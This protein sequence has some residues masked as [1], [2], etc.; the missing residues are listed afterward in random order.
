MDNIPESQPETEAPAPPTV[1][2]EAASA[3][4]PVPTAV[5]A[6]PPAPA[7][8]TSALSPAVETLTSLAEASRARR[9]APA[10]EDRAGALLKEL[11]SA[12]RTG[13]NSAFGPLITLPWIVGVN[14]VAAVWPG[15]TIP[16]RRHLLAILAKDESE[17]ARRLRLSLGRAIFKLEPAA[18]L[19]LAVAATADL[20]DPETGSLS[21]KHRQIFFNVFVGKGK[22]WLLQMPLGDLKGADADGFVHCAIETFP[23][24]PPLSQLS[25]LR[26]ANGAGRLKKL[27]PADLEIATKSI[28]RWNGK[29]Q[30]LLKAEISELPEAIVAVLKPETLQ[31]APME[32]EAGGQEQTAAEE[33]VAAGETKTPVKPREPVNLALQQQRRRTA[34]ID[35]APARPGS[36]K[37]APTQSVSDQPAP[38]TPAPPEE[39]N[40]PSRAARLGKI[41]PKPEREDRDRP[42]A[43]AEKPEQR[44]RE[45]RRDERP[46][47][48]VREDK[49][50]K[51]F[52]FKES[53][54]GLE[55][56]V[57][58]IR[59]ELE[60][61]K[62]QLRRREEDSKRGGRTIRGAEE[63]PSVDTEALIRHNAQLESAVQQLRQQLEDLA[64]HHEAVAESR[65]LHTDSPLPEGSAEQLKALLTIK[66][67]ESYATYTAMRAEPL[68]QVFR[69]H[70][71]DL[72]GT[73]F[74]ALL[75]EGIELEAK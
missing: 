26:W 24:C 31:P 57:A 37:P 32:T 47:R 73:V 30:R 51:P 49:T 40:I 19:K 66:L 1:T 50:R 33:T 53:L 6:E 5:E 13:I 10:D 28:A 29:L 75:N 56:Y 55:S 11:L 41:E 21:P 39:L 35:R 58:G 8:K 72:L 54:R 60:L 46:A 4:A 15:L 38:E 27:S 67:K 22:P 59:A 17:Q 61:A 64:A 65:L 9:L 44:T 48:E 12:G 16:M 14:A 43:E 71:R 45:E 18:G 7:P 63:K 69:L 3:P 70:Y 36:G 23:Y 2:P 25:I 20:K 62:A 52:D 68:D 74:E 42:R 34:E